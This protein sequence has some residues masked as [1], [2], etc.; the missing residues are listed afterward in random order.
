LAQLRGSLLTNPL[1]YFV[2]PDYGLIK[3]NT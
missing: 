3:K 1:P 2:G